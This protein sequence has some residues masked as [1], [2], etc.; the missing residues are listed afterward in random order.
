M[1]SVAC[2]LPLAT[3]LVL[4]S[5]AKPVTA[6]THVC[7]A[8][9]LTTALGNRPF[10]ST[11]LRDEHLVDGMLQDKDGMLPDKATGHASSASETFELDSMCNTKA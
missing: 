5:L 7:F 11:K 1:C 2:C 3:Y 8:I 9:M 10:G 6:L 4:A